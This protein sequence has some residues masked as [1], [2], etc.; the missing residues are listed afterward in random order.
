MCFFATLFFIR[1]FPAKVFPVFESEIVQPARIR[2]DI[3][4]E[5]E[6]PG[7][8]E[9][10]VGT[11]IGALLKKVGVKKTGDC[12][13]LYLKKKLLHSCSLVVPEKK[14]QKSEQKKR[15]SSRITRN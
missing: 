11:S 6:R 1:E 14:Y 8:Y 3:F 9:V 10:E 2:V 5:V 7:L 15:T 4:G 13:A 12:K